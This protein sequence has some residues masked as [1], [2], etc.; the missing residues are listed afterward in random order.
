MRRLPGDRSSDGHLEVGGAPRTRLSIDARPRQGTTEV[1]A[2]GG[3]T[4]PLLHEEERISVRLDELPPQEATV[5][6]PYLAD[7]PGAGIIRFARDGFGD[8]ELRPGPGPHPF[9]FYSSLLLRALESRDRTS[10]LA[11]V[12]SVAIAGPASSPIADLTTLLFLVRPACP[13]VA[14]ARRP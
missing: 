1:I 5:L 2:C 14:A 9:R 12:E 13:P 3:Q 11:V 6:A 10:G 4:L 8:W 7:H